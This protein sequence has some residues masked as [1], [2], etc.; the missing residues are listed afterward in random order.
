M[1]SDY[2]TL[3][4]WL[5]D[6]MNRTD[7]TNV[8]PDAVRSAHDIIVSEAVI[9]ADLTISG[10]STALPADFRQVDALYLVER[11][12]SQ[13]TEASPEITQNISGDGIPTVFRID[14]TLLVYP[15]PQ[16]TYKAKLLYSL[17]RTFFADDAATNAV[18]TRYPFAYAWLSLAE[19]YG[20]I[21]DDTRSERYLARGLGELRRLSM[22]EAGDASQG[23]L[24]VTSTAP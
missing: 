24:Q 19:L 14:T 10:Q 2:G 8:I 11:P 23:M 13:L 3:K 21:L 5:A 15:S 18:L 1:I 9:A 4:T 22:V 7:L 17:S 12:F 16:V 20:H 6:R